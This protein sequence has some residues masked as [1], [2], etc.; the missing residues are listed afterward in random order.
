MCAGSFHLSVKGRFS[1]IYSADD[2]RCV[3][4]PLLSL[5]EESMRGV[6]GLCL[7]RSALC[8]VVRILRNK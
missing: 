5:Q 1:E 7:H 3:W 4:R 6:E 8:C 2:L